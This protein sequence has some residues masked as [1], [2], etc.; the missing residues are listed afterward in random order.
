MTHRKLGLRLV[1]GVAIATLLVQP[2]F[3]QP[4]PGSEAKPS[5]LVVF[6]LK[7]ANAVDVSRV[8]S[9]LYGMDSNDPRVKTIRVAVDQRVN[10]L[11]VSAPSSRIDEIR[12]LIARL[13][14]PSPNAASQPQLRVI[15]LRFAEPDKAL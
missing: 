4:N 13:E 9:D 11:V 10:S 12:A 7:H 5:E 2:S 15:P 3:A 8:L 6:T 14:E 1:V